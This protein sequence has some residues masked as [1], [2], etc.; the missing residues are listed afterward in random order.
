MMANRPEAEGERSHIMAKDHL[1]KLT[2]CQNCETPTPGNFCPE[3]GQDS[4]EHRV[5][6]RLLVVG[7]WNDLFTFDNRFWRSLVLLLCKP[8]HLTNQF[9]G[10]RR[11]RYI[12]P[13]RMYLFISL[14]FFFLISA[15]VQASFD[16]HDSLFGSSGEAA[17]VGDSIRA[18]VGDSVSA[19]LAN[20]PGAVVDPDSVAAQIRS[21]VENDDGRIGVTVFGK[22]YRIEKRHIVNAVFNLLPKGMFLLLPVFAALLALIY[23]RSRRNYVEHLV[24]SLHFHSFV[25]ILLT[26][27]LLT[28][29]AA[30]WLV[31]FIIFYIYLYLA[32]KRVYGQG[33]RKTWLKHFL[34]T[35]AYNLVFFIFLV[36]V[37]A[38]G[39]YLTS[40]AEMYPKWFGWLV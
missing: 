13:A 18:A 2:I 26:V 21:A 9:I 40:L 36:L 25:F 11:V 30:V 27:A 16:E 39:V 5:A 31:A 23:I 7:L 29:S 6:L 3:C 35:N 38:G 14:I 12:P 19:A 22:K 15:F 20:V 32:M 17:A 24:F 34:L 37:L 10:G 8:G 28:S 1:P 33:W 4:R